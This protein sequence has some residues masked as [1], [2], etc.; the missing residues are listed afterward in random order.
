MPTYL[1]VWSLGLFSPIFFSTSSKKKKKKEC[2]RL[3]ASPH[4]LQVTPSRA[5]PH[6][7]REGRPIGAH[8]WDPRGQP[9]LRANKPPLHCG[10]APSH[11]RPSPVAS[12]HSERPPHDCGIGTRLWSRWLARQFTSPE[13]GVIWPLADG[14]LGRRPPGPMPQLQGGV[15]HGLKVSRFPDFWRDGHTP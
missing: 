10:G 14:W 4:S 2:C 11:L 7:S 9:S 12:L 5:R 3:S 15:R 6:L 1:G 13:A 8:P